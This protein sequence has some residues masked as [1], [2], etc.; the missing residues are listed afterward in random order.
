MKIR[1]LNNIIYSCCCLLLCFVLSD[2]LL[3]QC[4]GPGV[5]CNG[6]YSNVVISEVS[7]D[8][9]QSD[10][11]ND[12][13]VEIAG[14]PGTD[15][16]CMVVSNSEWAVVLPTGTTIPA[17]GA[18]LIAC[19][20]DANSN[21]GVGI[22]GAS[23]GLIADGTEGDFNPGFIAEID[24]DV[25]D[26]ANAN[27]YA[28]AATGF[29][30]DNTGSGDGDQVVLFQ[31]DGTVHDAVAWGAPG[32]VGNSD[33]CATQLGPYTL[34]DNDG[35]GIIND[36]LSSLVGGR[37]DGQNSS[38]VAWIPPGDCGADLVCYTMPQ[39]TDAVYVI[40]ASP[41]FKGC[42]SSYI[43]LDPGTSQGGANG[44][45]S[46]A[47]GSYTD[48][49]VDGNGNPTGV[50]TTTMENFTPSGYNNSACTP[51]AGEWSYTD[52]PNPGFANDVPSFAFFVDNSVLC[53]PGDVTFTV[54]VYN[55][56]RVS[57]NTDILSGV[58]NLQLGSLVDDP[59]AGGQQAWQTFAVAGA[60]TSMTYTQTINTPGM[61][62][63]EMV[64][65]DFSNCCG[66]SSSFGNECYESIEMT[67]ELVEP[68]V[69]TDAV[70]DCDAGDANAG[71]VNAADFITGGSNNL[72]ELVLDG[73][74]QG[75][76]S[77]ASTFSLGTGAATTSIQINVTDGSGCSSSVSMMVDLNCL[78]PPVC[79]SALDN[80]GTTADGSFCPGSTVDLCLNGTDFPA[81][82][83]ICWY[84]D[85][86]DPI[87]NM[88][89]IPVATAGQLGCVTIPASAVPS[90]GPVINEVGYDP[91]NNDGSGGEFVE[92]AGTP[93]LNV[94]CYI[95]TDGD[96]VV[97]FPPGT[98]IP[99]DGF[100]VVGNSST[101]DGN[102]AD[103]DVD[104][105]TCGCIG[106][107]TDMVLTN[108]GEFINLFDDTGAFL[109]GVD[110]EFPSSGNSPGGT[111]TVP[112]VAGC[113][114]PASVT[115]QADETIGN[116][117]ANGESISRD[118]DVTGGW[119]FSSNAGAGTDTTIGMSNVGTVAPPCFT[120]T[121]TDADC[122]PFLVEPVISPI[123]PNCT[124]ADFNY[125]GATSTFVVD[126][127]D[128]DLIAVALDVCEAASS[129]ADVIVN[130][131]GGTGPYTLV[132]TADGGTTT[133]TI[134]GF[135][136]GDPITIMGPTMGEIK[137]SLVSVTDEAGAMCMGTVDTDEACVN[138]RPQET[139]TITGS[140]AP[141]TCVPCDGTVTFDFAAPSPLA[142][143]NSYDIDYTFN[144]A[145]QSLGSVSF[146]FV[147]MNACPGTYD[148]TL[149]ADDFGCDAVV[150]SNPQVL[151]SFVTAPVTV[152]QPAAVCG[153][154]SIDV[155]LT[156]DTLIDLTPNY[157]ATD[158]VFYS[159]DP[160][161]IPAAA[162][163][164][165]QLPST[166]VSGIT[167]TTS[168][169]ALYT[170][171]D[172]CESTVEII[173]DATG[174]CP[175][176]AITMATLTPSACSDAGTPSDP[177][178]DTFNFTL[179]LVQ[180]DPIFTNFTFDGTALGLSA[181]ESGVYGTQYTSG[182][183]VIG[184]LA[185]TTV[186]LTIVDNTAPSPDTMCTI[187]VDV[188]VPV[189]CSNYVCPL[190]TGIAAPASICQ[191]G[192]FDVAANGIANMAMAINTE[193]DFGIDFVTFGA[194]STFTGTDPYTGGTSLATVPFASLT[195]TDPSQN[196]SA[197]GLGATLAA[198]VHQVCAILD[199]TPTG[200]ATCR[201]FTCL[202]IEVFTIPTFTA[203]TNSPVCDG[204]D[205]LLMANTPTVGTAPFTWDWSFGG[206]S[207]ATTQNFTIAAATVANSGSY[208]VTLTDANGCMSSQMV[209]VVVNPNPTLSVTQP[210]PIC[211]GQTVDVSALMYG[212]APTGGTFT[213][214]STQADADNNAAPLL[215]TTISVSQDIYVR[216]ELATT[217]FA[218]TL[219]SVV[220]NPNPVV[221]IADQVI[222]A[223]ITSVDLTA[224]EP[225]GQTGGAWTTGGA[226]GTAVASPTMAD[227]ST[228]PFTYTFTDTNG[229][230]ASDDVAYTINPLP[231]VSIAGQTICA[232]V[233]SVDLTA[234]ET[235]GQMGG[236]WSAGGAAVASPTAADPTNGPFTY[237][238]TDANGC[239]GS[240]NVAY[241]INPLPVI[242]IADQTIC[243][244]VTSVDLTVLEPLGQMGGA[245]SS[246]GL[247]VAN[248]TA[249]DPI[250]GP[251]TYT[252]T[253]ANGCVGSDD[254]TYN[255]DALPVITLLDQA[256]CGD[257]T[258]VDLTMLEPMGQTGGAWV[259]GAGAAIGDPTSADPTT[260][261]FT[262][263]FTDANGCTSTGVL[264]YT[265]DPLIEVVASATC[266]NSTD[267]IEYFV[268]VTSVT[269]GDPAAQYTVSVGGGATQVFTGTSLTF[270]P[271]SHSGTG[272]AVQIVS[273]DNNI[274]LSCPVS[275]E[276]LETLC[277][278]SGVTCD[279]TA[280]SSIGGE[281][282]SI[283]EPGTFNTITHTQIYVLVDTSGNI[284]VWNNTGQ[285]SALADDTYDVYAINVDVADQAALEAG[286]ITGTA[287]SAFIP[288]GAF[289]GLCYTI[290]T[291]ANFVVACL[292]DEPAPSPLT[293]CADALPQTFTGPAG[294]TYLWSDG[295]TMQS[296]TTSSAGSFT[297]TITNAEGCEQDLVYELIV[298]PLP[299][300]TTTP[301]VVCSDAGPQTLT[302][303]VGFTNLWF[304]G[305]T[306]PTVQ[307][308]VTGMYTLTIT[309]GNGCAQ[310]LI[311]DVTVNP[312]PMEPAPSPIVVCQDATP[313]TLTAP[314]GFTNLWFDGS[315]GPTVQVSV[316]GMYALTISDGNGCTQ[317]LIYDVTV[318][319]VPMEPAP[320]PVVV[321][322]DAAPVTLTAP[323]GFTN[324]WFDGTTG[325]TVQVSVT[326]MYS[327]TI[328]D[329]NG[330]TQDLIYDITV[331]A[332]PMEP[333]P[334][335][336][337]V[338]QDAT[339][340]TL[341]A[342]AGFTYVWSDVIGT[343]AQTLDVSTSGIVSVALT[344]TNGCMQILDYD[345][346]VNP[347]PNEP[348]PAPVV[349]CQDASPVILTGPAG[350]T[351]LWSDNTNNQTFSASTSGTFD[352]T[353]T[354][355]N[356][357][358]QLLSYMVTVNPLPVLTDMNL[359][360]CE[361]VPGGGLEATIDLASLEASIGGTGGTFA[362]S[363]G[364][365][366]ANPMSV[367]ISGTNPFVFTYT[368]TDPNFC[369]DIAIITYNVI[370]TPVNVDL[371]FDICDVDAGAID[372]TA[373]E[374][375][376]GDTGGTWSNASGVIGN[377]TNV[378]ATAGN[379][380]FT[381]DVTD[382]NGCGF[383]ANVTYNLFTGPVITA[384]SVCTGSSDLNEYFV[385]V[386]SVSGSDANGEYLV[387]D[388]S[389]TIL[390]TGSPLTFGPYIH[391]GS[392]L[393]SVTLDVENANDPMCM[394][395]IN[396]LETLC[397]P[398]T[399]CDCTLDPTPLTILA[400]SQPGTFNTNAYTNYYVLVDQSTA[401]GVILAW[402][403]TGLFSGL[404]SNTPYEV[405]AANVDDLDMAAFIAALNSGASSFDLSGMTGPFTGLC[406]TTNSTPALF[407][408]DC[409]CFV[410]PT[411]D[412]A[413]S[414]GPVC[415]GETFDLTATGT[416][417]DMAGNGNTN[418]NVLFGY[419][420]GAGVTTDPYVTAPSLFNGGAAVTPV[421][422]TAMLMG[423]GASLAPGDYTVVAY[424]APDPT[425]IDM[426]CNPSIAIDVTVN[427]LPNE[428][429][430]APIVVCADATPV[431]LT[432]PG[433]FTYLW[434][435]ASTLQT[436]EVSS[437][438]IYSVTLSDANGCEQVLDYD[439]TVN[440]LPNE[441]APAPIVVCADA[442]PITLTAPT[443][444]AYLW[445]DASTMQTLDVSS[446]AIYSVTLTDANGCEQVLD[447]DVTVNPLPN[448]PAP[449]PIVVCADATPVTL[450]A[451]SGFTYLWSDA[452]TLQTLDVSSTA[453]YSVTLS[454]AN[455]CVQILDYDV[456]V[457]DNPTEL[458]PMPL[459]AC[460]GDITTFTAPAGFTYLW[461]TGETT[462]SINVTTTGMN[463]LTIQDGNGCTQDLVYAVTYSDVP[464][465]NAVASCT[466]STILNEYF[467]DVDVTGSDT[468]DVTV[469]GVT[470]VYSGAT[471]TFGPIAHSGNGL[472]TTAVSV[473]SQSN[474]NCTATENV[475]ETLCGPATTCDCTLAPT[476][477]SILASSQ[478]GTFNSNGYT[479]VYVLTD[480]NGLV[481]ASNNTGLF[482]ALAQLTSYD[483]TA[484][485]VDDADLAVFNA[486]IST[487]TLSDVLNMTGG[488]TG[489][490]YSTSAPAN[491]NV[492]CGCF[493]CDLPVITAVS[494]CAGSTDLNEYFVE[495][496]V[497]GNN[498]YDVEINGVTQ[499]YAGSTLSFG[500]FTHSGSGLGT[501]MVTASA[502]ADAT[503]LS[504]VDVL[505]TLCGPATTCDCTDP[506]A[507]LTIL[508]S[509]Q[510]GTFNTTDYTNVYI[511]SDAT[512]AILASNNTGLFSGLAA[513][514]S[515]DVTAAN[516]DDIDLA[517][518]TSALAGANISD[519]TG[520]AGAFAGLCFLTSA[521]ANFN[522]DCGCGFF[523]LALTKT[524]S[525]PGPYFAGQNVIFTIEVF[526]Q[527]DF[528][529]FDVV[530]GDYIPA[531]G[532]IFNAGDNAAA[533][534]DWDV[535]L[536][537]TIAG[538]ILPGSSVL[539]DIVLQIDPAAMNG[540]TLVNNAEILSA[541]DA[542]GAPITDQDSTPGD[543]LGLDET[544]TD[545]DV[546]DDST[547][548]TDNPNDNDDYDPAPLTISCPDIAVSDPGINLC[549][550]DAGTVDL[551]LFNATVNPTPGITINW[552]D[553]PPTTG[554]I[555]SPATNVDLNSALGENL[556]VEVID[557]S[558][559]SNF[560]LVN[561][562]I[563]NVGC[564]GSQF[565]WNGQ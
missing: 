503:C 299:N 87:D 104:L 68:L 20:S 160:A 255:I 220:V 334:A 527:G 38:G 279:C 296:F 158:F 344:D 496:D 37:C 11:C 159:V 530:I 128:A 77:A 537:H 552:Y 136:S 448:E 223:D 46:H 339:P 282:L 359:L 135:A 438:A 356:G 140:S 294:F 427:P 463:T 5:A 145:T 466:G 108:G 502:Q 338:C 378:A 455:G 459:F 169:W 325:P 480:A 387:S 173:L 241:T 554:T 226:G 486:A 461:D 409:G 384:N 58:D 442:T 29:T 412:T 473:A 456:T 426:A 447:Y 519:V 74:S 264:S 534:N 105:D 471:L 293:V 194:G 375:Q 514:T 202:T 437:T 233:T 99:A 258:S 81:G 271:F 256:V 251:F 553:G 340:V 170:D 331:N 15:I 515:Y 467:I 171:V 312:V 111:E 342:P 363:G 509:S 550:T 210:D 53:A 41:T 402:N 206:A 351:Y 132:Y 148:I 422:G 388:G 50:G 32:A 267:L 261:P 163:A 532:L 130:I 146:P 559:C 368:F 521:P 44:S 406:Y 119:V 166:T 345:V 6:M 4:P 560:I 411:I 95:F 321:C 415:A 235:M 212:E 561:V 110:W 231:V 419:Y 405:I 64:W 371:V 65:D 18:F 401:T 354:D 324:L 57:D 551:T 453:I 557:L 357:C 420:A 417:F 386:S 142:M 161:T 549:S 328:S 221:D 491:F 109:D 441:P 156:D 39:I 153:D 298:N 313:V 67:V 122:G 49:P 522:T 435:D 336:I 114:N 487:A 106:G 124:G 535:A 370:Q 138:I 45:P 495:V 306:G 7:G 364:V 483:V 144:G 42:N 98:T 540:A 381:Y 372:L 367:F 120:Y 252:F 392:G 500:P 203:M 505:E 349:V 224:L 424:L 547:G 213:Y 103:V 61:F 436:L 563:R 322:Q 304:D 191:G 71:T 34:G 544:G 303:P 283:S 440:P 311:Y 501:Q 27:F 187:D 217:C 355:A 93:G 385:E 107:D 395:S 182:N 506:F 278:P 17:D 12:G 541:N 369:S 297:L 188:I 490:C 28:P 115:T 391:S 263:T 327:L 433:G 62:T 184:A 465:I 229:C 239:T 270:G 350:F 291:P 129:T 302:A 430:P 197:P 237:T 218:T 91:V 246:G 13:I 462:Q 147:L 533:P 319:P 443:G 260:G 353:I 499:T 84:G 555:L 48:Q 520:N 341:T 82:G 475:L 518:F 266:T 36:D 257:V 121:L 305:T 123:D 127:P 507:P 186:T 240:G 25:C 78:A 157:N 167:A 54:E 215:G 265:V 479:N 444:F 421:A 228:G 458:A 320:A 204:E 198:G 30:L 538:P 16:G 418:F 247:A 85:V 457:N 449:A 508:A 268:E 492:D 150:V 295:S 451:P 76:A 139:I 75:P 126:C 383:S 176:C 112:T 330:C 543:N 358:S 366:V 133:Q 80:T 562:T 10:G 352:L 154:G 315:T 19:A 484:A 403:N 243:A 40:P 286:L 9:G 195:G 472:G 482:S 416:L 149:A 273:V 26:A 94:G 343:T 517:A 546:D 162:L 434:S 211:E 317:D 478:P 200:D 425:L 199:S 477:L 318:N 288:D 360:V 400:A 275:V 428:P 189:T 277:G 290:S 380:V 398:P 504:T 489:L 179:D 131:A 485:N 164:T 35:N 70:I 333:A 542:L 545:N 429:A 31:P 207:V 73:V 399:T 227:P 151:T 21:C 52:H 165:A 180:G 185:G 390:Y 498:T 446:T 379:N 208:T 548:G 413:S 1:T 141:T 2:S 92:F 102:A 59:I 51:S 88:T 512:G 63:F 310:D 47:D 280:D 332:V 60:T 510:P 117:G 250:M 488:L 86:V 528:D 90:G 393:G 79:P 216:Y 33:N 230:F 72:Y 373:L 474:A 284:I 56:Q 526:N 287:I 190:I 66:S 396:V 274:G 101:I 155:D 196:A 276:V 301:L 100:L 152:V 178:D 14:A 410:C 493:V 539:V 248:A 460:S 511:L 565:P 314:V 376:I 329:G 134:A 254:V 205:L 55:Y 513:N 454:D 307:V 177:S 272:T 361:D 3:A 289:M 525:T 292:P 236:L 285:F 118:P 137:V 414:S 43:R 494:S 8:A 470:Q 308:S 201:P 249:A 450:T 404:A 326:G 337:V 168:V 269:G 452:S 209:T 529:V 143:G 407:N 464:T 497:S 365:L 183:V 242:T 323:V 335:P 24:F 431:T 244:D 234:L 97:V 347:L 175:S 362:D 96:F 116:G 556:Y 408:V 564:G 481:I 394:S 382:A 125:V 214:H 423:M 232:D 309:D 23:N 524:L 89:G 192:T 389:I 225:M 397:G 300:E 253:D 374:M 558:G 531:A 174:P 316:T 22:N 469:A 348:A 281:I 476:P 193:T 523:D 219:V 172:G 259:N 439:V 69:L 113:T 181:T 83:E 445:S 377:P 222:C 262:Y 346:T 468:Y 238:F 536:T 432:A 516:V 245:W